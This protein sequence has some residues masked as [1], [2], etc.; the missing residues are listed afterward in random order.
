[1]IQYTNTN[2]NKFW[3]KMFSNKL[4]SEQ[5]QQVFNMSMSKCKL[6]YECIGI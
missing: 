4:H 5:N 3:E 6:K 2:N 1:M